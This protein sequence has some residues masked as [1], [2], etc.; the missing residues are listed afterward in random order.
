[1]NGLSKR[2]QAARNQ[3]DSAAAPEFQSTG[4][5]LGRQLEVYAW[6]L[7]ILLAVVWAAWR[8]I[9]DPDFW[10]HL[11]FARQ[12]LAQD[13]FP[14]TDSLSFTSDNGMWISSGWLSSLLY[15]WLFRNVTSNGME[16]GT[17]V[18]TLICAAGMAAFGGAY[19]LSLRHGAGGVLAILTLLGV[20]A[21]SMR[22]SPRPD[23]FSQP[24]LL[25]LLGAMLHCDHALKRRADQLPWSATLLPGI[26]G[27]WANLH[28]GFL[29]G[30]VVLLIFFADL[31]GRTR[32]LAP[33]TP[34]RSAHQNV[35]VC[36][37]VACGAWI[38][39]PYGIYIL[40]LPWTIS[41]IPDVNIIFEWR[42]IYASDPGAALPQTI[43]YAFWVLLI[44]CGLIL[45]YGFPW[46]ALSGG[47]RISDFPDKGN[48]SGSV[49]AAWWHLAVLVFLI[50]AAIAQRRHMALAIVGLLTI[51][52]AH[53]AP[54]EAALKQ[55]LVARITAPLVAIAVTLGILSSGN[56][57]LISGPPKS[58][59]DCAKLPC[60][61][62]EFF[63]AS[64]PP[65]NVYNSYGMGGY[66]TFLN[67]PC[68]KVFIDGRLDVYPHQV[69]SDYLAIDDGTMP[70]S[71]ALSK[72]NLKTFALDTQYAYLDN[73]D[74]AFR[75]LERPDFRL[76]HFDDYYSA[77]VRVDDSTTSY[78]LQHGFETLNPLNPERTLRMVF[79]P[80]KQSQVIRETK[81]AIRQSNESANALAMAALVSVGMALQSGEKGMYEEGGEMLER[82]RLRKPDSPIIAYV[83]ML[84]NRAAH[85][86]AGRGVEGQTTRQA[87]VPS[88]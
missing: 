86:E 10:F 37:L 19:V 49:H 24:M 46:R 34:A 25:A 28:A 42:T 72:Y 77:I 1:M 35:L 56:V 36:L 57:G 44:A 2:R 39:N 66:M 21:A 32:R 23:V 13:H 84:M 59:R 73:R 74:L 38:L 20:V 27:L 48:E 14:R 76:V 80:K 61:L 11:S 41:Q 62:A 31:W 6:P 75:L 3:S 47:R 85:L 82:A 70:I 58:G 54:I 67:G 53:I 50:V 69:W 65:P 68:T 71:D 7:F 81:R 88:R 43:Q 51:T 79:D 55:V 78:I 87:S 33:Q 64:P 30:L 18:L 5:I 17:G 8:P 4:Q 45:I 16:N 9:R 29:M 60:H 15:E 63:A 52:G 26:T 22:F 40:A 83:T 12:F